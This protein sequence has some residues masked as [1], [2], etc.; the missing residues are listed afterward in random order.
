MAVPVAL[1]V[2][3]QDRRHDLDIVFRQQVAGKVAGGVGEDPQLH[4]S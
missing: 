1:A 2:D 3:S 4:F